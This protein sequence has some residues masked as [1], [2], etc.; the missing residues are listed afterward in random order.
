MGSKEADEHA[1]VEQRNSRQRAAW[2]QQVL[3]FM[4]SSEQGMLLSSS[5]QRFYISEAG[6][7]QRRRTKN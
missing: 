7:V 2:A 3:F 4:Q 6:I 5:L 1:Q